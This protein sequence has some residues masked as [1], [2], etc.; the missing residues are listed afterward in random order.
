MSMPSL[1]DLRKSLET[2]GWTATEIDDVVR[3]LV[4]LRSVTL[5]LYRGETIV[6]TCS[7]R[8]ALIACRLRALSVAVLHGGAS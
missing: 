7:R 6:R 2:D 8:S 1:D 5:V 3:D 4:E